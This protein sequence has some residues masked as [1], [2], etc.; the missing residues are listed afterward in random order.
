MT[1][2]MFCFFNRKRIL[3]TTCFERAFYLGKI[4]SL[5]LEFWSEPTQ[6]EKKILQKH[7]R[8]LIH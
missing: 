5:L 7:I 8:C 2:Y 3:L 6:N 1:A 4:L